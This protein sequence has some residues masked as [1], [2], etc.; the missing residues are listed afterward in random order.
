[1]TKLRRHAIPAFAVVVAAAA[2]LPGSSL[3]QQTPVKVFISVDMEGIGG[4]GTGA[5]TSATGKDYA[6]GRRLM[7]EEVNAVVAAIFARGPAEVL[8]N[9]SH[10]DMQNL[11][12]TELDARVTYVQ[13]AVKPHGMV[14]GLD[15]TFDAAIF[16]GYHARAGTPRGFLAHTGS[17]IVKGLWLNDIEVGEGELNAAYA[18]ELGVPVV[19][20]SG[21]STFV[22]QFTHTVG[23]EG[24]VTKTAVTPQ[25][26]RLRHPEQVKADL[27]AAVRRVL[28]NT[29]SA[30]PWKLRTPIQVRL[31]FAD[32]TRPQI[33]QAI[34]GVRQSDG[35]TVEF[36]AAS[37]A[38]AYRLIRL[39]YRFV[40]V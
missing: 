36:T 4:I 37:M 26:A 22:A 11:L 38:E 21:D 31:Q 15:A 32:P 3:A 40:S 1:M 33:L 6:T 18:G 7:T 20:V 2:A 25:S 23:A 10:G 17:G 35:Y 39:M 27:A 29:A 24:V 16:I 13:G 9:D 8:V 34:P 12:H 5:M 19:L 30:T 14:E 28:A